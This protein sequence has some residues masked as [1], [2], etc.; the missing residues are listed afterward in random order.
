[1]KE[2]KKRQGEKRKKKLIKN[3]QADDT[4]RKREG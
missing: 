2:R 3:Y 1:M 4:K